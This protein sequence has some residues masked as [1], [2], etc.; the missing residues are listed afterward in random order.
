LKAKGFDI[1]IS[2]EA[3]TGVGKLDFKFSQGRNSM[4]II[5]TKL[6]NNS[7]L[8]HGYISQL[9]DYMN[10]Q[11]ASYGLFVVVSV[12]S[13]KNQIGQ[14]K[15]LRDIESKRDRTDPTKNEIIFVNAKERPTASK[16]K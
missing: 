13:S 10:S 14:L 11:H 7:D 3:D 16:K 5:E 2:P 8:L 12:D 4:V 9:P 6:S 1:D 15:K